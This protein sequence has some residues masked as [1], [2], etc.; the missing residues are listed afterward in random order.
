MFF[1]CHTHFPRLGAVYNLSLAELRLDPPYPVSGQ[2]L[3]VGLHPW[4]ITPE[5][6][7]DFKQVCLW[8]QQP[9]VVAIGETGLDRVQ[10]PAVFSVQEEIFRAH[11]AL[12]ESCGKP[13]I[14]HCVKAL[15]ELL[16]LRKEL[17]PTQ[18]WVFHGFR[19][20]PQ[21]AE[22]LLRAGFSLSFGEHFHPE[23]VRLCPPDRICIETDES[24]LPIEKIGQRIKQIHPSFE[25]SSGK[26]LFLP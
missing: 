7:S 12:S 20:K 5:W 24:T 3:S 21:Q 9:Q 4:W 15:D 23:S 22:S 1:D 14:I 6:E 8:A 2:Y 19:G 13:I 18:P 25:E 17:R 16:A 26:D 10:S 11:I